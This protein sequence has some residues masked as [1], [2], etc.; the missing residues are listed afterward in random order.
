MV[1]AGAGAMDATAATRVAAPLRRATGGTYGGDER[2]RAYDAPVRAPRAAGPGCSSRS[3]RRSPSRSAAG[4]STTTSRSRSTTTSRS[5]CSS[6][7]ASSRARAVDLI[8]DDGFEPN[9]RRLPNGE[10]PAGIVFEQSPVE[11]TSLARGGIVTILVSTGQEERHRARRRRQAA[12]GCGRDADASRARR[13]ERRRALGQAL[14]HRD[15]AG[16]ARRAPRSSRGRP[17][18]STT[19]RGRSRSPFRP[20]SVSTTPTALQQLQ[21][22]GFAVARTDVESDAAGGGRRQPGSEPDRRRRRRARPSTSPSRTARRRRRC[23]T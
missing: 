14:R 1:L 6:T 4:S 19:R 18:G 10:Q 21:A 22:A 11:G 23:R 5:S 15:G 12:D 9:V 13:E 8:I 16:S 20:S 17:C 2:Y 7:P 3:A